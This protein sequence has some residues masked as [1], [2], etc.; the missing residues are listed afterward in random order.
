MTLITDNWE[1]MCHATVVNMKR[2]FYHLKKF[3]NQEQQIGDTLFSEPS[4]TPLPIFKLVL[5]PARMLCFLLLNRE[6][7]TPEA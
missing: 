5:A 6:R 2:E 4:H 1:M 7:L 3:M